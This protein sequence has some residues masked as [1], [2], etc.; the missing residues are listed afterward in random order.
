MGSTVPDAI[1]DLVETAAQRTSLLV[2]IDDLQ[3]VD[4]TTA[5]L[6]GD[7]AEISGQISLGVL[8][9][10][11]PSPRADQ[12]GARAAAGGCAVFA[13]DIALGRTELTQ[14]VAGSEQAGHL[15]GQSMAFGFLCSAH[16]ADGE[17]AEAISAGRRS[18]LLTGEVDH[19]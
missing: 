9:A 8:V 5:R 2:I 10:L 6:I 3:W 4:P 13:G 1:V 15:F 19:F 16:A 14:V 7:L 17:L 18:E 11:R 12:P